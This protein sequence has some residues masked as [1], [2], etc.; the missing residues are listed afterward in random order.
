MVTVEPRPRKGKVLTPSTIPCLQRLP[1]INITLGCALGC[2]YCYI[3]GYANSPGDQRVVLFANTPELLAAELAKARVKPRR[4]FFSPSSDPFQFL[5]EVREVTLRSMRF[6]LE[7]GVEVAFLTK[8]LLTD[9]CFQ[10]FRTHASKIS[11]QFGITT[12]DPA[13]S[14]RIEPRAAPPEVRMES[15][16]RLR[17]LGIR[18]AARLDPLF[19]D[20]TDTDENLQPLL[21]SLAAAGVT[22][23]SASLLFIRTPFSRRIQCAYAESARPFP[24]GKWAFQRFNAACGPACMLTPQDRRQRLNRV[25]SLAARHGIAVSICTCKN[26]EFSG[27]GCGIAGERREEGACRQTLFAMR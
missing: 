2:C 14:A 7:A 13:L 21:A 17:E 8:G 25:A 20:L 26:P 5:P 24:A 27:P 4:V 3:Q 12:G 19:P 22:R 1:T 10:L 6:L 9:E 23:A 11:A 15:L 18:C 16:R